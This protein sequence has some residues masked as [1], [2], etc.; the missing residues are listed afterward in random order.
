MEDRI[1]QI[2]RKTTETNIEL[3]INL[4]GSGRY[5][6]SIDL[7]FLDHMIE[8]FVKHGK[9]DLSLQ[10]TGDL[11]VDHHHT[12]EDLGLCLGEGINKALGDKKGINRYGS[13]VL[14]MDES[15]VSVALDISGRPFLAY[16]I[17]LEKPQIGDFDAEIIYDFFKAFT[18]TARLTLH[19][20]LIYG[21]NTHH[22]IEAIFKATA[23][24][25]SQAVKLNPNLTDIPST[26][27]LL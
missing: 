23:R 2:Q 12:V 17:N 26:K 9:F 1:G 21:N 20:N 13:I 18:D 5:E 25:L 14:P 27:G 11:H 22:I 19:I 6:G 3:I 10:A 24:A 16:N 8:L 15:L 4:D 7:P